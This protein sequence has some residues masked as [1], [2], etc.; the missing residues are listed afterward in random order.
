M[1]LHPTQTRALQSLS[2]VA[3]LVYTCLDLAMRSHHAKRKD[4]RFAQASKCRD[5]LPSY[6]HVHQVS[7]HVRNTQVQLEEFVIIA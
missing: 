5:P 3:H 1:L 6:E 2:G 7:T 4:S